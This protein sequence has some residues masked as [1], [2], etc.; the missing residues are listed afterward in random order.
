MVQSP[1]TP[2]NQADES[3]ARKRHIYMRVRKGVDDDLWAWWQGIPEK[4]RSQTLRSVIREHIRSTSD[5]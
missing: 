5:R 4:D 2:A 3:Q 1:G